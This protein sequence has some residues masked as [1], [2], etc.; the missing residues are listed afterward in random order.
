MATVTLKPDG[1]LSHSGHWSLSSGNVHPALSDSDDA[2]WLKNTRPNQTFVL[3]LDMSVSDIGTMT[4][5]QQTLRIRQGGKGACTCTVTVDD[6]SSTYISAEAFNISN[7]SF[8]DHVGAAHNVSSIGGGQSEAN[9]LRMTLTTT[10]GTQNFIAEYSL[11]VT[12]STAG[13]GHMVMNVA[14]TDISS[15]INVTSANIDKIIGVD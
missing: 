9:L 4:A 3:S 6:G 1:D 15:V 13:Y 7:A 12:Y 14:S 8:A 11:A 5:M 10:G 2:T